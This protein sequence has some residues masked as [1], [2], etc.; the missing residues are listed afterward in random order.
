MKI[1]LKNPAWK[2][3]KRFKSLVRYISS[4]SISFYISMPSNYYYEVAK[5]KMCVAIVGSSAYVQPILPR[6]LILV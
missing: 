6:R 4:S 1:K 3:V 2:D 5:I